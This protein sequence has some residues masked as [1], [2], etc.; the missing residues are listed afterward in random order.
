MREEMKPNLEFAEKIFPNVS[1]LVKKAMIFLHK[2]YLIED[3]PKNW[4]GF[5]SEMRIYIKERL[6]C[7]TFLGFEREISKITGKNMQ[8]YHNT[9]FWEFAGEVNAFILSVPDPK[10]VQNF[11]KAELTEIVTKIWKRGFLEKEDSKY[12]IEKFGYHLIHYYKYLL[13]INF[14]NNIYRIIDKYD[15][16]FKRSI[17]MNITD[18]VEEIWE[19]EKKN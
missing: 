18:I 3:E 13:K 7:K 8:H 6:E 9:A 16:C 4:T 10:I 5:F 2:K 15:W 14:S 19:K 11:T 17:N 1:V 12:Y